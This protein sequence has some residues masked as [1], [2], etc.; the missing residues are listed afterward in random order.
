MPK[1]FQHIMTSLLKNNRTFKP[2]F[3]NQ[4]RELYTIA[5]DARTAVLAQLNEKDAAEAKIDCKAGCF[6][7]CGKVVKPTMPELY[8]ILEHITSTYSLEQVRD[9][10]QR[11]K[12]HQEQ[13]RDATTVE[14]RVKVY[15]AFL[16]DNSCSIH[17]VKPLSC[18]AYTST[19]VEKCK[20]FV[21]NP[22]I[23]IPSSICHY[24]PYQ[25]MRKSI[26]KS[27]FIAGFTDVAEELNEGMLRLLEEEYSDS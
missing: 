16:Q 19:D 20:E 12:L 17:E 1:V 27:M 22:T 2:D 23:E 24:T 4:I 13:A 25:I 18:I 3:L 14:K 7:C 9:L 11:L 10:I 26:M 15:C 8:I 5:E 6:H 21:E